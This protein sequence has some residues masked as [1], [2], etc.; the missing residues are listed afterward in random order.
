MSRREDVTIDFSKEIGRGSFSQV[1]RGVCN[2][3][4]VAVKKLFV[5]PT[6]KNL[7]REIEIGKLRHPN[8]ISF[9]GTF[10]HEGLVYIITELALESL[11]HFLQGD[12]F[13][14]HQHSLRWAKEIAAG[15]HFLH[16][17]KVIHRDLKSG[18]VL[19]MADLTA[20]VA[21]FGSAKA[22]DNTTT[23]PSQ[24]TGT[25]HWMPPEAIKLDD[26]SQAWDVHSYGILLWELW[27]HKLPF[28]DV[29][30]FRLPGKIVEGLRPPVPTNCNPRIS[31]LMQECWRENRK[32]RPTFHE[33]LS[34]LS[35]IDSFLSTSVSASLGKRIGEFC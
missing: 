4:P 19:L 7:R 10:V 5:M 25:Y 31:E 9:Y 11:F 18:N 3:K 26:I 17:N 23:K 14:D 20:K 13:P 1:F 6:E 16:E 34:R 12:P 30:S 21:D 27:T 33:I 22:T 32:S 24:G 35:T 28:T 29:D 15:V 2:S 8:I